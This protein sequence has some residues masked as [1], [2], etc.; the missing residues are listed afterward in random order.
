M[1]HTDRLLVVSNGLEGSSNAPNVS[2]ATRRERS[3]LRVQLWNV[4]YPRSE[5]EV[6]TSQKGL[7]RDLAL[8]WPVEYSDGLRGSVS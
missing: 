4:V 5:R 3:V 2:S 7:F 6:C 1:D 8:R